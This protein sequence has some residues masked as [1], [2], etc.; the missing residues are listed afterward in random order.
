M[1][2]EVEPSPQLLITSRQGRRCIPRAGV[3]RHRESSL[4]SLHLALAVIHQ[5][6]T[7]LESS[8]SEIHPHVHTRNL[9]VSHYLAPDHVYM[10]ITQHRDTDA[11]AALNYE[12]SLYVCICLSLTIVSHYLSLSILASTDETDR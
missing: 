8:C 4:G 11:A 2:R 6:H 10:Y 5:C 7:Q 3:Q 9:F 12:Q 1:I